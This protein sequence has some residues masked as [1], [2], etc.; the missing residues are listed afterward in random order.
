M[1]REL[2]VHTGAIN[3]TH[4]YAR[5]RAAVSIT[6]QAVP[7]VAPGLAAP[8]LIKLECFCFTQQRLDAGAE[9]SMPVRF[10]VSPDLPQQVRTLTL[11]YTLFPVGA[12]P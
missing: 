12:M 9:V 7:S 11:S 1:D 10:Y 6:G 4:F 2:R 8:H 5:N 3:T